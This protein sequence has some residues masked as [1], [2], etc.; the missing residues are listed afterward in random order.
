MTKL[1][2][3]PKKKGGRPPIHGVY[4]LIKKGQGIPRAYRSISR[5]LG[6]TR[7]GLIEDLGGEDRI[8]A[9]QRVLI[10]RAICS[11]GVVSLCEKYIRDKGYLIGD[12]LPAF[13]LHDLSIRFLSWDRKLQ[14]T[15]V[16]LG[17]E[18]MRVQDEPLTIRAIHD[19]IDGEKDRGEQE[20]GSG[21][22][23]D[24]RKK[25]VLTHS[26]GGSGSGPGEGGDLEG[27]GLLGDSAKDPIRDDFE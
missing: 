5:Y 24:P 20:S 6:A 26:A 22:D 27:S 15:L 7:E 14:A 13:M 16:D 12:R 2:P 18:R 17:L 9:A 10:D 8:S 4:A 23:Q 19:L 11:L 21:V 25:S 3:G 1:R